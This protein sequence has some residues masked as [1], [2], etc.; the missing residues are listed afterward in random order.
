MK[1]LHTT[2]KPGHLV[3]NATVHEVSDFNAARLDTTGG[4]W[5]AEAG[6]FTVTTSGVYAIA[7]NAA[8]TTGSWVARAFAQAII[9]VN[10]LAAAAAPNYT[11]A[12]G[13][14]PFA[15]GTAHA[16]LQLEV[17][18][19]VTFAVQQTSGNGK[20]IGGT[21]ANSVVTVAQQA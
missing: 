10:G 5:D 20:T 3:P 16:M 15:T 1:Y 18:D 12:G 21:A 19:E 4:D 11:I 17:G 2:A 6:K 14:A 9:R 7:F 8:L 13:T